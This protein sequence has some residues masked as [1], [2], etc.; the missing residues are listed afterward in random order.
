MKMFIHSAS[1]VLK[2]KN[3][4]DIIKFKGYFE[5]SYYWLFFPHTRNE[6]ITYMNCTGR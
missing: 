5:Y 3:S 4:Y 1:E 2:G 6:F